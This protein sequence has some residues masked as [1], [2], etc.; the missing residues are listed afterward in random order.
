MARFTFG[1][2]AKIQAGQLRVA[3]ID[4]HLNQADIIVYMVSADF[5]A[6]DYYKQISKIAMQR[7]EE[8][9][10]RLIPVIV[11]FCMW[12]LGRLCCIGGLA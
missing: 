9:I 8:K 10:S 5:L 6:S 2:M 4:K 3:E 1:T 7:Q 11:R 12:G